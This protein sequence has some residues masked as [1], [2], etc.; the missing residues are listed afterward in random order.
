M[1]GEQSYVR[2]PRFEEVQDDDDSK[3]TGGGH[4]GV[5]GRAGHRLGQ[6]RYSEAAGRCG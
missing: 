4:E 1:T 6:R 3:L 5:Y 2:P